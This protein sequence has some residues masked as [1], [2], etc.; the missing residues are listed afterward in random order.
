[1][2][3]YN[4]MVDGKVRRLSETEECTPSSANSAQQ[5]SLLEQLCIRRG[6]PHANSVI[7]LQYPNNIVFWGKCF[8][9]LQLRLERVVCTVKFGNLGSNRLAC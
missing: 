3:I 6:N 4:L 8:T 9:S 2:S 1:M 5:V 7:S